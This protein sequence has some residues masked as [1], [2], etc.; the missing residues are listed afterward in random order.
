MNKQKVVHMT[1]VHN[2]FDVRIFHKECKS[3]HKAVFDVSLIAPHDNDEIVECIKILAVPKSKN[4]LLRM[5]KTT[6]QVFRRA[7]KEKASIYHFHDPELIPMGLL[8]KLLGKNVIYD[9]HE[10]Y[11]TSIK[12][13]DYF[14]KTTGYAI[15]AFFNY[16]ER[17]CSLF[18]ENIIAEKYYIFRFPNSTEILNYQILSKLDNNHNNN[19]N[20]IHNVSS[21]C[22]LLYTGS[23]S[24]YRGALIYAA[25]PESLPDIRI[26]LIGYCPEA[27]YQKLSNKDIINKQLFIIDGNK[28]LPYDEMIQQYNS[29]Q[30]V[31]GLAI[32][33]YNPHYIKKILGKFYE[34][35]YMKIP[36]ICSDFPVWNNFIA[37]NKCGISVNPNEMASIT[38]AIDWLIK[39]PDE[40]KQMGENGHNAVKARYNWEIQE[41]K[42]ISIYRSILKI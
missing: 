41:A 10:D 20:N 7:F 6:W 36:I 23:I 16:F 5:I 40:A 4:R 9:I 27:L 38:K 25:I 24:V 2:P 8:L 18:F 28:Y 33:P 37:E 15:A 17:F 19:S 3:L 29:K 12:I 21:N 42:L 32:F 31:C 1:S 34:Y 39:H 22:N 13:K 26:Y 35:M 11:V 14:N 30:W